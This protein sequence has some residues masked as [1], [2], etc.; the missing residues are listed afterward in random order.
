MTKVVKFFH[1]AVVFEKNQ[2]ASLI[3]E[4]VVNVVDVIFGI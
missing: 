2:R 3:I 4:G 1:T